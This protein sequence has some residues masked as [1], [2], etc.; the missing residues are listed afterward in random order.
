M[1]LLDLPSEIILLIA[2]FLSQ[3][4]L[5]ALQ[6]TNQW[7]HSLLYSTLLRRNI[8]VLKSSALFW[9]AKANDLQLAKRLFREG[10]MVS[11]IE[12]PKVPFSPLFQ[13]AEN[14][15][16][17][18]VKLLLEHGANPIIE[19]S[20]MSAIHIA[21]AEGHVGTCEILLSAAS[22][23]SQAAEDMISAM[24]VAVGRRNL[25]AIEAMIERCGRFYSPEVEEQF[26]PPGVH[27][28]LSKI[29]ERG[30]SESAIR[31]FIQVGAKDILDE[32]KSALG[33]AALRGD[34]RIVELLLN[35]GF[36]PTDD[37]ALGF[38]AGRGD[39]DM[40]Q[41]FLKHGCQM[42][43]VGER[44]FLWAIRKGHYDVVELL[45]QEGADPS[46][47][48]KFPTDSE[49]ALELG[50]HSAIS[51]AIEY[52][53]PAILKLLIEKGEHPEPDDIKL[54]EEMGDSEAL[55]L[56]SQFRHTTSL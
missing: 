54:A 24:W 37:V 34:L 48:S 17:E 2:E 33:Q 1:A 45:I 52:R 53:R 19:G 21:A 15:S 42:T 28:L 20:C 35:N 46:G 27:S 30:C 56:L 23:S 3:S 4:D 50:I 44:P 26:G 31:A 36:N 13:A 49:E 9:A 25:P 32:G 11:S 7:S 47:F 12:V 22:R 39:V 14:G 10:A 6:Q 40:I 8:R 41:L 51:C 38:A 5:N 55:A 43:E 18:M 29:I 16:E